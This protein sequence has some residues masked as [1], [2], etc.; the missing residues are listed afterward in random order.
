M[1]EHQ[2]QDRSLQHDIP[3]L[4]QTHQGRRNCKRDYGA[5]LMKWRAVVEHEGIDISLDTFE[6]IRDKSPGRDVLL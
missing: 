4:A 1:N 5:A 3:G 6:G 2:D